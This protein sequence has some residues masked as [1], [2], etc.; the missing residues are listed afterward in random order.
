MLQ[1][2]LQAFEDGILEIFSELFSSVILYYYCPTVPPNIYGEEK[3]KDFDPRDIL[4]SAKFEKTVDTKI[5][6]TFNVKRKVTFEVPVKSLTLAKINVTSESD[7]DKLK[8]SK[9]KHLNVVYNIHT[10]EPKSYIGSEFM[11]YSFECIE[12]D[13]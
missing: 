7:I 6:S 12:G 8:S 5:D 11:I 2:D 13:F 1:S 10:L 9:I 4:A 3:F